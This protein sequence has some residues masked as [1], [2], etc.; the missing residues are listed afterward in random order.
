V[1]NGT[2]LQVTNVTPISA[3]SS[4]WFNTKVNVQ[5]FTTDFTFQQSQPVGDGM[6]F[7]IQNAGPTA[8]GETGGGLGYGSDTVGNL[9][10]PT[11]IAIKFDLFDNNGEGPNS[12]GLYTG[13]ASPTTPA[14]TLGGGVD[15]HSGH[16]FSVHIVYDGTT[17]TMTIT[18]TTNTA[19]IFTK[20]G[21]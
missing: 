10:M 9:G 6:T 11:S 21:P 14:V 7:A 5:K 15:L 4:A 13:G 18:D 16:I 20:I 8:L 1:L 12:T 19:N 17:L 2:R 3:D